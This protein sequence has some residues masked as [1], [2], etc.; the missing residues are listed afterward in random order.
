MLQPS[1]MGTSHVGEFVDVGY[2]K[3]RKRVRLEAS[4]QVFDRV[5]FRCVGWKEDLGQ[6]DL[7]QVAIAVS[8]R[9]RAHRVG[10]C[11]LQ[12]KARIKRPMWSM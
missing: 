8:S 5:Q 7:T 3:I 1:G 12:P 11:G 4:P 9:S 10:F 6:S 2:R